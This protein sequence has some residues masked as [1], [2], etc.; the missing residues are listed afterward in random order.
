MRKLNK[1]FFV[2]GAILM[3]AHARSGTSAGTAAEAG[4][5]WRRPQGNLRLVSV[6]RLQYLAVLSVNRVL[7][8]QPAKVRRAIPVRRQK[9][10]R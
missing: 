2:I 9:F 5:R 3:A 1:I 10:R 8:Q 6:S 4:R 7:A